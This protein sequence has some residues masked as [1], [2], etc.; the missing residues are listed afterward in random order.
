MV[1]LDS[2]GN[3]LWQKAYGTSANEEARTPHSIQQVSDGG[4]IV[5]ANC[6]G[7]YWMMKLDSTGGIEWQKKYGGNNSEFAWAVQTTADGGYVVVGTTFSFVSSGGADVWILRL[8]SSG[9]VIWEKSYG[10]PG[11][12]EMAFAIKQTFDGGFIVSAYTY[13]WSTTSY[14]SAWVL[15]LYA[16]GEIEWQKAYGG[17][18]DR[19]G[20]F[21]NFVSQTSYGNYILTGNTMSWS[22]GPYNSYDYTNVWAMKLNA[23][24][25]VI[26]SKAYGGVDLRANGGSSIEEITDGNYIISGLT[27]SYGKSY[28]ENL[29]DLWVLKID[30]DGQIIWEKAYGGNKED[31]Q[32][33]NGSSI[34]QTSDG[35]F[36]LSSDTAS[37]SSGGTTDAWAL[38]LDTDGNISGGNSFITKTS[39]TVTNITDLITVISNAVP[40]DS[41]SSATTTNVI[42][43]LTTAVPISLVDTDSDGDSVL[44]DDDN[45]H[46]I[47]NGPELGS[48]YNYYTQEVGVTCTEDCGPEWYIWCENFQVDSDNDGIG[49]VCDNCP[50]NCNTQQLDADSDG[51]GDVCDTEDDGCFSCGAGPICEIEC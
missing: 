26:W 7:D 24:G 14:F 10:G 47:P 50:D 28:T 39:A 43:T 37:F 2:L 18:G 35:G 16:N 3:I 1:K 8:D 12:F 25:N 15:K 31:G 45:C 42:P 34:R 48:C 19:Q 30:P 11:V 9:N 51:I 29:Y 17:G 46:D 41:N 33:R 5:A 27:R 40:V 13:A 21:F 6:E 4:Y 36:I 38:K 20:D 44:N 32:C 23:S 49:N 22:P